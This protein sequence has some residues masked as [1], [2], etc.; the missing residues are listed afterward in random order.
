MRRFEEVDAMERTNFEKLRVYELAE[1]LAD[2]IWKIAIPWN[3]FARDTIGKQIVRAADG[4][5]ANIAEGIGRGSYQENR[6]F[7]KIARGSL[8]EVK[9]WLRRAFR[10]NLLTDEH[11]TQL[12]PLMDELSPKLNAYLRSIGKTNNQTKPTDDRQTTDN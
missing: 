10:R 8:N 4:I 7:V 5:G 6:R 3:H 2:C 1:C 11:V 9:H 12:K